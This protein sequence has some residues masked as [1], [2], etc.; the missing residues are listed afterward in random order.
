MVDGWG[1]SS[2]NLQGLQLKSSFIWL[3]YVIVFNNFFALCKLHKFVIKI[4]HALA[5]FVSTCTCYNLFS[6]HYPGYKN[7][8]YSATKAARGTS[9]SF[10]PLLEITLKFFRSVLP[11][12][13]KLK[14]NI[15]INF[16][17]KSNKQF[18]KGHVLCET[19]SVG[20]LPTSWSKQDTVTDLSIWGFRRQFILSVTI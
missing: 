12:I 17:E 18:F 6:T 20:C 9:I 15:Q 7:L 5:L 2:N 11:P 1:T 3:I 19:K 10:L 4:N 14:K 16:V 13:P 8:S